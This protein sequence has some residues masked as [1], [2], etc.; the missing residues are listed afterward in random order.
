MVVRWSEDDGDFFRSC[1]EMVAR[2]AGFHGL[3]KD[4]LF[5]P[6]H[7]PVIAFHNTLAPSLG[8]AFRGR[9]ELRVAAVVEQGIVT[10]VTVEQSRPAS[11]RSPAPPDASTVAAAESGVAG[12]ILRLLGQATAHGTTSAEIDLINIHGAVTLAGYQ[13]KDSAKPATVDWRVTRDRIRVL[14]ELV[15]LAS[16]RILV[17]SVRLEIGEGG[18]RTAR[19]Q[20]LGEVQERLEPTVTAGPESGSPDEAQ[21][22]IEDVN[23][24]RRLVLN[25]AAL[26]IQE[27]DPTRL[28][29]LV[30]MVAPFA[31]VRLARIAR[32]SRVGLLTK[33]S[34]LKIPKVSALFRGRYSVVAKLDQ[35]LVATAREL[36]ATQAGVRLEDFSRT[37]IAVARVRIDGEVHYLD[38]GNIPASLVG[39]QR[40]YDSEQL[41]V[42]QAVELR[43]QGR[44]VRIEQLYSERIP[45]VTCKEMLDTH[46]PDATI[47]YTVPESR[48]LGEITRGEALMRAYGLVP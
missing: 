9:L 26:L 11:P 15:G 47:F 44:E 36:R 28:R 14:L 32:M 19:L 7:G 22:I 17:Y 42:T 12:E 8:S 10:G 6:M 27:Q 3:G 43:K 20:I 16:E 41:I 23:R 2:S 24:S 5:A 35:T 4:A 18:W 33:L 46:F 40:G 45:C 39:A 37:N 25:T 38:A 34:E 30:M 48:R 13:S 21:E 29:N 31:V 1:V